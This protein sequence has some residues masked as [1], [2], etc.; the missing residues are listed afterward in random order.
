MTGVLI[1]ALFYSHSS[2]SLSANRHLVDSKRLQLPE[3]SPLSLNLV[4]ID[5]NCRKSSLRCC[6]LSSIIYRYD[7]HQSARAINGIRGSKHPEGDGATANVPSPN[8][9]KH[10]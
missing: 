10:S 9:N 1:G 5:T 3:I 7:L 8:S 6:Y 4:C 2:T